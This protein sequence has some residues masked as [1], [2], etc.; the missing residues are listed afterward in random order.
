MTTT[1]LEMQKYLN[2]LFT[3]AMRVELRVK[4]SNNWISTIHES[5]N[6]LI[7]EARKNYLHNL[8]T[9]LNAPMQIDQPVK[10]ESIYRICRIFFDFDPVRE[11]GTAS[12]ELQLAQSK[13]KSAELERWL[14]SLGWPIPIRACSGNGYHLQYRT[15]LPAN[16][17]TAEMLKVIY[18]GFKKM[19]SDDVQF[20]PAVKNPGRICRLYGS[21]NYKGGEKR[22]TS[23]WMPPFSNQVSI[24]QVER[25]ANYFAKIEQESRAKTAKIR[26]EKPVAEFSGRSDYRTLDIISLFNFHGLYEHYIEDNKHAVICPWEDLHT[27]SNRNDTIIFDNGPG[28]WPGFFCHHSHC[29]GK[30]TIDVI[31]ELGGAE[32]FCGG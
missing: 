3:D 15:A 17:E 27:E 18:A 22:K 26:K 24:R 16:D 5:I 10:N 1:N 4:K 12:T 13:R 23:V 7:A 29:S 31:R 19:F 32:Q 30:K 6:S 9:S 14:N 11:T 20:D 2:Q 28:E 21:I 8:Y 25:L